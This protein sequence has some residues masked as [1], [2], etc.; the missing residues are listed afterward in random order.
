MRWGAA[1][2]MM[3]EFGPDMPDPEREAYL[4]LA[5]KHHPDLAE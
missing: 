5:L 2:Q 1:T 3:T 4:R